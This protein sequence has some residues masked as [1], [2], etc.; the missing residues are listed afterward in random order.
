MIKSAA[1]FLLEA[2]VL[3]P[4]VLPTEINLLHIHVVQFLRNYTADKCWQ[5]SFTMKEVL[6]IKHVLYLAE[7]SI[8]ILLSNAEAERV[9]SFLWRVYTKERTQ[10]NNSTLEDIIRVRGD[11]DFSDKEI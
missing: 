3:N 5:R 4:D 10:L 9:Y 2:N 11:R 8:V 6:G 1:T 7:I